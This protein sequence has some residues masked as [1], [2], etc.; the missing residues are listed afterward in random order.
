M[1]HPRRRT[2]GTCHAFSIIEML[3]VVAVLVLLGAILMPIMASA[4]RASQQIQC[5]SR[6]KALGHA[7]I[8]YTTDNDGGM[9]TTALSGQNPSNWIYWQ[10]GRDINKSPMAQYLQL[11]NDDLRSALRCPSTPP[12][13]Q[14]GYDGGPPYP[15]TFTMNGFLSIHPYQSLRF[16]RIQI[17]QHKILIYDENEN[18]DDDVFWYQT[19][20]DTIAGRHGNRSTQQTDINDNRQTITRYMGNGLFFDGHVELVDNAMCHLAE[21]NDPLWT[22]N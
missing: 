12:E 5:A 21:W 22:H 8:C 20:R 4:R 17:P 1:N 13:N 7:F 15:L 11:H 2:M 16:A 19:A 6:L 18:S 14:V 9:P 3:I 10:Q